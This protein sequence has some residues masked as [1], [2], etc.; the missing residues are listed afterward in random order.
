MYIY[1][2]YMYKQTIILFVLALKWNYLYIILKLNI[3]LM[4]FSKIISKPNL[5]YLKHILYTPNNIIKI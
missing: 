4:R 3:F 5:K 1:I 2:L